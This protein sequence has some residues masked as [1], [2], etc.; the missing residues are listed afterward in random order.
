[1]IPATLI[2]YQ[3]L[4][5]GKIN[6]FGLAELSELKR[7]EE[8]TGVNAKSIRLDEIDIRS[9]SLHNKLG[10]LMFR[11]VF[12][13]KY[14]IRCSLSAFSIWY[15]LRDFL[16]VPVLWDDN[17]EKLVN[18]ICAPQDLISNRE[19][20]ML[21]LTFHGI[22]PKTAFEIMELVSNKFATEKGLSGSQIA[23]QREYNT[24]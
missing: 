8:I 24:G 22:E 6:F 14:V 11:D 17:G 1:M 13:K 3:V 21:N 23:H 9:F 19:D 2:E 18:T 10:K 4:L 15:E 16:T 5:F 20:M 12:F 7:M